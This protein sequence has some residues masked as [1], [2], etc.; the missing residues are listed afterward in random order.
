MINNEN[1][2]YKYL[3]KQLKLSSKDCSM[4]IAMTIF[5]ININPKEKFVLDNKHKKKNCQI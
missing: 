4:R 1:I 5:I 3:L 2:K